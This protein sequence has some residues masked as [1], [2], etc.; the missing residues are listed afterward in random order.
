MLIRT[1]NNC[2]NIYKA[3]ITLF[4]KKKDYNDKFYKCII[5]LA[6]LSL[7]AFVSKQQ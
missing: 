2:G 5:R 3:K 6:I 1:C 7:I 4:C